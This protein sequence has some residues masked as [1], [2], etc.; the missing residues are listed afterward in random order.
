MA[1]KRS[2]SP[3]L[4]VKIFTVY[5]EALTGFSH[6]FNPN[7]LNNLPSS[8]KFASFKH[9]LWHRNG[10]QDVHFKNRGGGEGASIHSVNQWSHCFHD[11]LQKKQTHIHKT[12]FLC[13][14]YVTMFPLF[15]NRIYASIEY[16]F[17]PL[18]TKS[19]IKVKNWL[20]M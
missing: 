1:H 16:I 12:I 20:K 10:W 15:I 13:V 14:F 2:R 7:G 19:F 17:N 6:T 3:Y 5:T 4:P 9:L 18:L 11:L 8:L